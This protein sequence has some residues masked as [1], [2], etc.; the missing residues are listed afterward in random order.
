[1]A[2]QH[3]RKPLP[4]GKPAPDF[5]L[6]RLEGGDV[7][8]GELLVDGPVLLVFYKVTCPVCQMTLPFL[9][10]LHVAGT[11]RVFGISQN[12]AED[13]RQFAERF[14][15]TF[16]MLLDL[17]DDGFLASN[18]YGISSVPTMYAIDQDSK[19][20]KVMQGWLKSDMEQLGVLRPGD[21]VPVWKAG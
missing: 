12:D 18:D 15:V 7:S 6:A 1:M 19:I 3:Q 5:H 11:T 21:N 20:T 4:A 10:R 8:L 17:E 16:P 2:A 13:T 14:G 9:E